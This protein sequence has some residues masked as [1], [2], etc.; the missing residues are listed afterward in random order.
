MY[1]VEFTVCVV[2]RRLACGGSAVGLVLRFI[3]VPIPRRTGLEVMYKNRDGSVLLCTGFDVI[4]FLT[5]LF[6]R[7]HRL[8]ELEKG[9]KELQDVS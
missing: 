5:H 7:H 6:I 4:V 9:W 1:T 8:I 2:C 3:F